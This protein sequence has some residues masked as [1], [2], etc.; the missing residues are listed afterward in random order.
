MIIAQLQ[1]V[2]V[3]AVSS[4]NNDN[5]RRHDV[6]FSLNQISHLIR[7]SYSS[8]LWL[9][10]QVEAGTAS[11]TRSI[12]YLTTAHSIL[13]NAQKEILDSNA[14]ASKVMIELNEIR[15]ARGL[16]PLVRVSCQETP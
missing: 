3:S 9:N 14:R 13:V 5:E 1:L 4:P 15:E 7:S 8:L 2:N 16:P 6:R 11:D 10:E 12:E